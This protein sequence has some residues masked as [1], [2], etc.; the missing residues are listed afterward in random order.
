MLILP[1]L[2][3]K[4]NSTYLIEVVAGETLLKLLL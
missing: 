1:Y 3:R 4:L 2:L